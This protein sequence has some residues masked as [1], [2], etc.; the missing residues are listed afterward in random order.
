[1]KRPAG[2]FLVVTPPYQAP[3]EY[4]HSYRAFQISEVERK[5]TSR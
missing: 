4:K 1:V 2:F 5:R 3:D